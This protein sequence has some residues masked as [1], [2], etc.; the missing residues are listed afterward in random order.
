V[1]RIHSGAAPRCLVRPS[2]TAGPRPLPMTRCWAGACT[3]SR[4]PAT[5]TEAAAS[6]A[7]RPR[8][9][10]RL[11][12]ARPVP[13]AARPESARRSA[14]VPSQAGAAASSGPADP[15]PARRPES[16]SLPVQTSSQRTLPRPPGLGPPRHV[17][18]RVAPDGPARSAP[19]A[20]CEPPGA[21]LRAGLLLVV[22]GCPC[23]SV[24]PEKARLA[25]RRRVAATG[26]RAAAAG[27][28]SSL[29]RSGFGAPRGSRKLCAPASAPPSGPR[30]A[31]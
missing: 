1:Q 20:A 6:A 4:R 31:Q 30:A 9:V 17:H 24:R 7:A 16:E 3:R 28:A 12:L 29:P 2:S 14:P 25:A 23:P 10:L 13:L 21:R 15:S 19:S 27:S 5:G 26:Q 11:T 22:S 8:A 18:D